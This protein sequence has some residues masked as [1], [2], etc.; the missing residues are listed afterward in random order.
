MY[1]YIYIERERERHAYASSL[2]LC[3]IRTCPGDDAG[4]HTRTAHR[5]QTL[6]PTHGPTQQPGPQQKEPKGNCILTEISERK[7]SE[8]HER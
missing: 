3:F 1:I 5:C 4:G 8:K 2:S 6:Y 7:C